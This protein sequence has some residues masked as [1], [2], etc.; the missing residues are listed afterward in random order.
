[1]IS[2]VE[3]EL[4]A[5]LRPSSTDLKCVSELYMFVMFFVSEIQA[6]GHLEAVSSTYAIEENFEFFLINA[7]KLWIAMRANVPPLSS[8]LP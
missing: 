6:T 5:N 1:M 8:G 7:V 4:A 2:W 3:D